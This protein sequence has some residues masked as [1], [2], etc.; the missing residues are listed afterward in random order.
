MS[1]QELEAE[2]LRLPAAEREELVRRLLAHVSA[3]GAADPLLGLGSDP[4]ACG[5]ADAS[6]HHDR[7]LYGA[8]D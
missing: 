6:A 1:V 2:V 7:H 3:G 8:A 5:L 4:V